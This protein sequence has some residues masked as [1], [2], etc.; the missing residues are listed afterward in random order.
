MRV[1]IFILIIVAGLSSCASRNPGS[2]E[3]Y[4]RYT[5]S[6]SHMQLDTSCLQFNRN[7]QLRIS[8][9]LKE[10]SFSPP[11]S[12]G[13]QFV[14]RIV[15]VTE[16]WGV[17]DSAKMISTAASVIERQEVHSSVLTGKEVVKQKTNSITWFVIGLVL[18]SLLFLLWK[19]N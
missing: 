10:F 14:E 18:V 11:D 5:D 15:C 6:V 7:T 1:A 4:H 13:R 9:K 12:T 19:T 2:R 3:Q 16:E 8:S 17:E